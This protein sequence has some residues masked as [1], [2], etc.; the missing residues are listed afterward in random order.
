VGHLRLGNLPQTRSWLRVL[1]LLG[2][3]ADARQVAA[4]TI[5]ASERLLREASGDPGLV[6]AIWYLTQI[7]LAAKSENFGESLRKIGL[8]VG[9]AP[10]IFEI[11]GALSRV[12]DHSIDQSGARTDVGEMAQ[13]AVVET[14]T[15]TVA[16]RAQNL[17]GVGP[18]EVRRAFAE[19]S[20]SR[21]F[22]ALARGAFSRFVYR[23]LTYFLSRELPNQVGGNGRFAG[24]EHHTEFNN[25]LNRQCHEAARIVEEFAGGWFSKTHFER[26]ITPDDAAGFAHVAL[27]KIRAELKKRGMGS[28]D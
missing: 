15:T 19:L 14:L 9:D 7:P 11:T 16:D 8:S 20:T 25:A 12:I 3:G 10:S 21:N 23:Y 26:G 28:G 4:A 5:Q 18:D 17:F 22:G 27:K 24:I 1:G 2:A 13:L 6:N